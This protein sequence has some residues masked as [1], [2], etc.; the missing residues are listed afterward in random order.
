MNQ[1]IP[2]MASQPKIKIEDT[3]E[4]TCNSCGHN[5]FQVGTYMRKVSAFLTGTGKP[6]YIPIEQAVECT[7]CHHTND[8]FVPNELKKISLIK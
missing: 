4:V 8:E 6:S 1:E 5:V 7:K 3:T 2:K